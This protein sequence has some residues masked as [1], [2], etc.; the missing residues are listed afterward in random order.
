MYY[1]KSDRKSKSKVKSEKNISS[2]PKWV[3]YKIVFI[4][5]RF[6]LAVV[7]HIKILD[8]TTLDVL[9]DL[10]LKTNFIK[11]NSTENQIKI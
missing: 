5:L 2:V 1:R 6:Y 9:K 3:L 8:E 11:N 10:Y 4:I 7:I